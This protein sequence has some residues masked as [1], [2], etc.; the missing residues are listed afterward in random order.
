VMNWRDECWYSI[1]LV[2][3][4]LDLCNHLM[5]ICSNLAALPAMLAK[6]PALN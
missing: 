1:H 4:R 3:D 6:P 5:L 2:V